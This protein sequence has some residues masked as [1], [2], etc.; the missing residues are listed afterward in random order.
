MPRR[1]E[2]PHRRQV[3]PARQSRRSER[4][5]RRRVQPAAR[6]G[7]DARGMDRESAPK[8]RRRDDVDP[9]RQGGGIPLRRGRRP[10]LRPSVRERATADDVGQR[11]RRVQA[12]GRGGAERPRRADRI[13]GG[14][15]GRMRRER[16][17]LRPPS[18]EA[19]PPRRGARIQV[20]G[21]RI[22][23][24]DTV[25]SIHRHDRRRSDAPRGHPTRCGGGGT[26]GRRRADRIGDR[27]FH[28]TTRT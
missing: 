18:D 15:R 5:R 11:R 17:P 7:Q 22:A 2:T 16:L 21:L 27:P 20:V 4:R 12:Q 19:R 10:R 13:H 25:Q 6:P 3:R 9:Y 23:S 14:D 24:I 8:F 26:G 28:G 1:S